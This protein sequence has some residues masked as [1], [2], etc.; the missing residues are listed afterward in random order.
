M[1]YYTASFTN[2]KLYR[3]EVFSGILTNLAKQKVQKFVLN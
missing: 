3:A 1:L 2:E